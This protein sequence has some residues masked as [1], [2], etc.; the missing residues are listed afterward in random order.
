MMIEI[1]GHRGVLATRHGNTLAGFV[2]ALRLGVD[3]IEI[4]VWLTADAQLALRHD[5]VLGAADIR[6]R[7][8]REAAVEKLPLTRTRDET[9]TRT[10][11]LAE[12][13][14]LMRFANASSVVL[15]IE[16]KIDGEEWG[17]YEHAVVSALTATLQV[18]RHE[19]ALRVRS[20]DP[21]LV[22]AVSAMMPG[23][24]CIA[25]SGLSQT[26]PAGQYPSTPRE[27]V[28]RAITSGASAIAPQFA[29][30]SRYL[31]DAAHSA[32]LKVYSWDVNN[33]A[34][35]VS[36]AELHVDGV[37]VNDVALCRETLQEHG[38]PLPPERPITLP[39]LEQHLFA[40]QRGAS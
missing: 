1:Q 19:Q 28:E 17:E 14:A 21:R 13:L 37:C 5:A 12:T 2:E 16:V 24:P 33:S 31:V 35:I 39:F 8:L 23:L 26:S 27:L 34:E 38:Y 25:L 4:D 29:I 30:L 32:G 9:E 6:S 18:H 20:F 15:D 10:P 3:A 36:A 7:P 11:N 22:R 40:A